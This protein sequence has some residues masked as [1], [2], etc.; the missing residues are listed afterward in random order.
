MKLP[1]LLYVK[2]MSSQNGSRDDCMQIPWF[3]S[4]VEIEK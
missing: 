4:Q 3:R 1:V 2:P